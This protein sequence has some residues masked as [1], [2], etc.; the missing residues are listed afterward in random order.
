MLCLTTCLSVHGFDIAVG[1][2]GLLCLRAAAIGSTGLG[3][4]L[5]HG[6]VYARH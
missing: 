4:H 5:C 2:C 1:C 6:L 3:I